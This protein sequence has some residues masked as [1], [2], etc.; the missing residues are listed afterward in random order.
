VVEDSDAL[1]HAGGMQMSENECDPQYWL[2][3]SRE[4]LTKATSMHTGEEREILI[5]IASHYE[6]MAKF[7]E[8]KKRDD[9]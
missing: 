1:S 8:R 7:L 6:G 2:R 9:L 5:R 3:L 4:A